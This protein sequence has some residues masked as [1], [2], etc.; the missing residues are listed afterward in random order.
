MNAKR[1]SV[2]TITLVAG[3]GI[4]GAFA[5][6]P[7]EDEGV[8]EG[9]RTVLEKWVETRRLI[10]KEERDWR[11]G[12]EVL[13]SRIEL[14]QDSIDSL[15]ASL[16][17]L[18]KSLAAAEKKERELR[19]QQERLEQAMAVLD[20]VIVTLE[21]RVRSLVD[22]LPTTID[23]VDG[24]AEQ[25]PK[26]GEETKLTLSRRFQNVVGVLLAVEKFNREIHVGTDVVELGDGS[27]AQV[28]TVHVGIAQRYYVTKKGNEGAVGELTREGWIWSPMDEKG[29]E[30]V[31]KVV[32]IVREGKPA[33]FV[34]LPVRLDE[35]ET[36]E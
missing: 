25:I 1:R 13:E 33:E 31:A 7:E 4:A 3:L 35:E 14:Q 2:V 26:E 9:T 5:A 10:A 30:A 11:L 32:A 28:D 21:S 29:I 8:L 17:E 19:D 23:N 6:T 20:P 18:Q 27:S 22:R 24:F 36:E 34:S 16:D 15:R 12:K